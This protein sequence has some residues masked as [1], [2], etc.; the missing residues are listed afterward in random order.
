MTAS[1]LRKRLI[2]HKTTS[3][4]SATN[5]R[6]IKDMDT[7]IRLNNNAVDLMQLGNFDKVASE[8]RSAL[9]V[10]HRFGQHE[11]VDLNDKVTTNCISVRSVPLDYSLFDT[12]SHQD[13]HA[14][15]F[16]DRALVIDNAKSTV[17]CSIVG[18]DC[19]TAVVL[20]NAALALHLEGRR[21]ICL[22]QTS[23]KK[24]LLLYKMASEIM[25]RWL[26]F[27]HCDHEVNLLVYLAVMNNMGHIH[28]H[29]CEG[30]EAQDCLQLLHVGLETVKSSGI[31]LYS[32]E[33]LLFSMNAL[34]LRGQ[35]VAAAAAA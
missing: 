28:S 1:L 8:F 30:R 22:Q 13:H 9:A 23:F 14:F 16:F 32:E 24:A 12:S 15:S 5:P 17:V 11:G 3:S 21:N 33:Y 6:K 18:E 4:S 7:T 29:F 31:D 34:I 26:D 35:E 2:L 20:F 27:V 19:I 25:E 10:L